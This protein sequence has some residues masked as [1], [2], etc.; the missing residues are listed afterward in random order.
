MGSRVQARIGVSRHESAIAAV[1]E[2]AAQLDEDA[3][4]TFVFA[5]PRYDLDALASALGAAF[6]GPLAACT[7]AGELGPHGFQKDGLVGV[8][9]A[10]PFRAAVLPI[11]GLAPDAL[12]VRPLVR[13]VERWREGAAHAEESGTHTHG[14]LLVD[15]LAVAEERLTAALHRNLPDLPIVGGSAGDGLAF[16][17]TRVL[18]DGRFE[19]DAATLT[20]VETSAPVAMMK[21]QHFEPTAVRTVV[22]AA[23]VATRTVRELDGEP[24]ALR[25]AELVG[26]PRSALDAHVFSRRP[27][28][29]RLGSEH[30]VRSIQRANDDDSLSFFCAIDEGI[31]LAL[32]SSVDPVSNA[33]RAFR[34]VVRRVGDPAVVLGFDCVLRRLEL[35]RAGGLD[36]LGA[37]YVQHRVVGFSTYGEQLDGTHVN[38]TFTGLAIGGG[39]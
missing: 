39:T 1:A 9:L 29:L 23:D 19:R 35:E 6:R 20:L 26:V 14:V 11:R 10:G 17:E 31:V 25:Y 36:A 33:Q 37:T 24:A 15:G 2:L 22:T 28:M 27:V 12:D 4:L 18:V 3:P 30:W 32:G 16:R 34:D 21:F 7:T 5:S 8:S 38:Q 13:A